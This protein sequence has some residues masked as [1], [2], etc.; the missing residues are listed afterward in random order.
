MVA[1][2]SFLAF[3]RT[4]TGDV[5]PIRAN[6]EGQGCFLDLATDLAAG[7]LWVTT[8]NKTFEVFART[9]DGMAPP[10]RSISHTGTGAM[11]L[12]PSRGE[13]VVTSPNRIDTFDT[14]SGA[15]IRTI[16]GSASGLDGV[17]DVA[18]AP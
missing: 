4:A 16:Q 5:A 9:A 7:E 2:D 10:L 6:R 15:T 13:A 18:V 11:F 14:T 8:S 17:N 1:S 3:D 12:D